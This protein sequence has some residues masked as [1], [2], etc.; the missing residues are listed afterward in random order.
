MEPQQDE[1]LINRYQSLGDMLSLELLVERYIRKT[2]A[3]FKRMTRCR[4]D[5]QD[6]A[7]ESLF[8][9]VQHINTG[10]KIR[11]FANFHFIICRNTAFD[12]LRKKRISR[13]FDSLTEEEN[14]HRID[15]DSYT[16]WMWQRHEHMSCEAIEKAVAMC[17]QAFPDTRRRN[18]ISDYLYGY[19]MNEIA[20]R[21]ACSKA[22]AA[23]YWHR[24]KVKVLA[25]LAAL[26]EEIG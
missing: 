23:S 2:F 10:Q 9:I 20:K 18:I 5:A 4:E 3:F 14:V 25:C 11:H 26:L 1:D 15:R 21:N 8:R 7:Q 17:L 13:R 12:Y 16:S 22:M 24:H 19:S 6:L